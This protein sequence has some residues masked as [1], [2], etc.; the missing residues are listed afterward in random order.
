MNHEN[1]SQAFKGESPPKFWRTRYGV[2]LLAFGAIASV[3]LLS[4]HRAHVL[5]MLP[6]LLLAACPLLHLFMHRGHGSHDHGS[7]ADVNTPGDSAQ[8]KRQSTGSSHHH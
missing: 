5:G 8:P 4:E 2:G 6:F 1:P 7:E 3:F